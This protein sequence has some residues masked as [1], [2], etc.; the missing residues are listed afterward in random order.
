[1][2]PAEYLRLFRLK[3]GMLASHSSDDEVISELF[4]ALKLSRADFTDTF[5][6]LTE[7]CGS[8]DEKAL[9]TK[10][11]SRCATNSDIIEA[12][13]RKHKIFRLLLGTHYYSL[14]PSLPP[15]L[16]H[17]LTHSHTHSFIHLT[18]QPDY[19]VMDNVTIVTW[20]SSRNVRRCTR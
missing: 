18:T 7:H 10:I 11:V 13:K 19:A 17:S 8:E 9:I 15:S 20:G 4:Q 12:L 3:L 1:M 2:T 16:T 6:A 14:P 5:Q